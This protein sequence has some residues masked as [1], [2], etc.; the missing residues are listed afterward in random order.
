MFC[1]RC[2]FGATTAIKRSPF[3]FRTTTVEIARPHFDAHAR[4]A[5]THLPRESTILQICFFDSSSC[6]AALLH[7]PYSMRAAICGGRPVGCCMDKEAPRRPRRCAIDTYNGWRGAETPVYLATQGLLYTATH[8][9]ARTRCLRHSLLACSRDLSQ[10]WVW[11]VGSIR[12][13]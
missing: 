1:Q 8:A 7:T 13:A 3:V 5:N 2:F 10:G 12:V 6:R 4:E 9:H 11:F